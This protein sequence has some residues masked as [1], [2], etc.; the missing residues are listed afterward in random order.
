MPVDR[1]HQLVAVAAAE[2]ASSGYQ[3]ASLN[4]IIRDCGM[5]KSSFYYFVPSKEEL[6]TFVVQELID[7][8]GTELRVPE[9]D[10]FAGPEFWS[11][12]EAYF[13]G[14]VR[15]AERRESFLTLGR[16]FYSGAPDEAKGTVGGALAAVRDWVEQVLRVGRRC[17]AVRDDLP[18]ALQYNLV[19]GVLQIFDEWTVRHYDEFTPDQLRALGDAQFASIRRLL[20]P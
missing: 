20:A 4:R 12:L 11:R 3:E 16:M 5:S 6:F 15:L 2:F 18:D 8:V 17:G 19:T 14:L 10:E 7:E 9:P 13:S 1:R